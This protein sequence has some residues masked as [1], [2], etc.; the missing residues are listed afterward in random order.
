[1]KISKGT[2]LFLAIIVSIVCL[3]AFLL[4]PHI[5]ELYSSDDVRIFKETSWKYSIILPLVIL[6]LA[7]IYVV[8]KNINDWIYLLSFAFYLFLMSII[9]KDLA[10]D[11]LLYFNSKLNVVQHTKNYVV[12]RHDANKVFHIYDRKN[13]FIMY[14]KS[15]R[16]IDAIRAKKNLNCLYD[17]QNKDTLNIAYKKGF[18]NIKFLE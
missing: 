9:W 6:I 4:S 14:S 1:M 2:I 12:V 11:L 7:V 16:K 17:L 10:D 13:E 15:L 8:R 3:Q 5:D 18:L